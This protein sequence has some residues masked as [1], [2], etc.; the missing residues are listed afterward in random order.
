VDAAEALQH[1]HV[2]LYFSANW[3]PPC[4]RFTPALKDFYEVA[5]RQAGGK[6]VEVIFVPS[7][8]DE[9]SARA[10]LRDHMGA[11][12]MVPYGAPER[13]ALKKRYGSWAG[14]EREVLGTEGKRSGI[15]TLV[16]V[17]GA[18]GD[19]LDLTVR[20]KIEEA[21][22]EP[23]RVAAC[24]HSFEVCKGHHSALGGRGW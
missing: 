7:D 15:P 5:S 12:L 9:A 6:K 16:L 14:A 3:C 21:A 8:E 23:T 4:R 18:S 10:Y 1:K 19:E 24:L 22:G 17:D 2:L 13:W 11:W 20:A